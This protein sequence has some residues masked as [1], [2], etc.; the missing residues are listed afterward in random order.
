MSTAAVDLLWLP[1]GAGDNSGLVRRSGRAFEAISARHEHR[2][3]LELYH[4][5][6]V[7]HLDGHDFA[8][9]MTP[10]WG[11]PQDVDR[12]VVATGSVGLA[13]LGRCR[14]FRYEVH[15]WKDGMIPDA[16]EADGPPLRLSEDRDHAEAVLR[17]LPLFPT[18]TWGRDEQHLGEMWNS[19][20]LTSWLLARSGH[21]LERIRPPAHG[22]AP[23]WQAGLDVA[24]RAQGPQHRPG[25]VHQCGQER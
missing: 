15:A 1:L 6:L 11:F 17:L 3:A 20:S 12:G 14:L 24:A 16:D 23:G 13:G 5:A 10:A 2:E 21:D 8:V 9:E 4:S 19:N 22:R 7:I 25:V 18:H